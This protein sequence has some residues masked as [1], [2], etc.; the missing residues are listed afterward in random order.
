MGC[1]GGKYKHYPASSQPCKYTGR[2][3]SK[4]ISEDSTITPNTISTAIC[5]QNIWPVA[6]VRV[7]TVHCSVEQCPMSRDREVHNDHSITLPHRVEDIKWGDGDVL[8]LCYSAD[9]GT[10]NKSQSN[11]NAIANGHLPLLSLK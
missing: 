10:I 11:V 8:M 3:M 1:G 2:K 4:N 6:S 5:Y 9:C 7:S